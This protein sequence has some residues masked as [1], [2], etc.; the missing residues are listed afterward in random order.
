MAREVSPF[1][2]EPARATRRR[3]KS[4]ALRRAEP[5]SPVM[6]ISRVREQPGRF[7]PSYADFS[8]ERSR[9]HKPP[10]QTRPKFIKYIYA[11]R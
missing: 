4:P 6:P 3:P 2:P 1:P 7:L 5:S 11:F 10:Y 9:A 8:P